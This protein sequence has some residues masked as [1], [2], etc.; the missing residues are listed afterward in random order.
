[1]TRGLGVVAV[2]GVLAVSARPGVPRPTATPKAVRK[3][4]A[5]YEPKP[6]DFTVICTLFA[7]DPPGRVSR[8]DIPITYDPRFLIGARV[9][10]VTLGASPWK[11]GESLR[12]MI[13][14]PTLMLGGEFDGQRYAMTFSRFRPKSEDDRVWFDPETRYVLRWIEKSAAPQN[15]GG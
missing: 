15:G 10:T 4:L 1:V 2:L 8:A 12:F 6:G 14:S 7:K 3:A 9:E 5:R 11:A 13:H